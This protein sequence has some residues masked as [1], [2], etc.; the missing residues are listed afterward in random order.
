MLSQ[1]FRLLAIILVTFTLNT[2]M[3]GNH[4]SNDPNNELDVIIR[5]HIQAHGGEEKLGNIHALEL[6]GQFTG[7]SVVNDFKTIKTADGQFFSEYYLGKHKI[8][9]GHDGEVFWTIDP[10]QGF[11][12]PRKLNKVEKHVIAQKAEL[13]TPFFLWKEKNYHVEYIGQEI[14]DGINQYVIRLTRPGMP[15]ET[16]YLNA[17]TYL[18]YK[19]QSQW[20]DFT[21]PMQA[22]TIFDDY[23]ETEGIILPHYIEQTYS[24]RHAV[25]EVETITLNPVLNPKIFGMP[26][27]QE[28]QRINAIIGNWELDVDVLTRTGAWRTVDSTSSTSINL[29]TDGRLQ[30]LL[31][32]DMAFPVHATITLSYNKR[33]SAYQLVLFNEMFATTELYA[34]QFDEGTLIMNDLVPSEI[35][36]NPLTRYSLV[37]ETDDS[38]R[39][40][41]QRSTDK[42]D[43]W[44]SLEKWRFRR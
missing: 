3:Y 1:L 6:R 23:R 22:E 41:R 36:G 44:T 14:A 31:S 21:Y 17:T 18:P 42:G 27:I 20:V 19:Y 34:G 12:F 38:F 11:D 9:E 28:M 37:I 4:V 10:W 32:Y 39:I 16:W 33:M 29:L 24:T 26:V 2:Q 40:E 25:T 15:A 13:V 30:G 8:N 35:E 7:F 43:S 5:K